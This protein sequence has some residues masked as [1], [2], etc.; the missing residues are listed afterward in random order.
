MSGRNKL[1]L[2]GVPTKPFL[3]AI[4]FFFRIVYRMCEKQKMRK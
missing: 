2:V 3:C 1:V 4:E